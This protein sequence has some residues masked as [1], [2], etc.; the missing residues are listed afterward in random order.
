M[1]R[2]Q[3]LL[4]FVAAFLSA[5]QNAEESHHAD[6]SAHEVGTTPSP[7]AIARG[8]AQIGPVNTVMTGQLTGVWRSFSDPGKQLQLLSE[9]RKGLKYKL[10]SDGKVV[11]NGEWGSPTDCSTCNLGNTDICFYLDNGKE[12]TCCVI[13]RMQ[14][15]TLQFFVAGTSKLESFAKVK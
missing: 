7:E 8:E 15:D 9:G 4:L 13:V 10:T 11:D 14:N 5:C 6:S 2:I 12:K 1:I 3:I